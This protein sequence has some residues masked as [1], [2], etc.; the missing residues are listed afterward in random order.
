MLQNLLIR[1]MHFHRVEFRYLE[2]HALTL[3]RTLFASKS[4]IKSAK[5]LIAS[6]KQNVVPEMTPELW[7]AKRM[8]DSTLHPGICTTHN[9]L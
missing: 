4:D 7:R 2:G 9:K 6:Y 8:L 5:E 1:G 3:P